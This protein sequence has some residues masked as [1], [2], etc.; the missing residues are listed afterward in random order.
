[1]THTRKLSR[2]AS[3][4][5]GKA[6]G[7][8]SLLR[9]KLAQA[10]TAETLELTAPEVVANPFPCYEALR[11]SGS[12]HFLPRHDFWLVLGYDDVNAAL[13]QPQLFSNRVRDYRQVDG[14]LLG[15][16]PPEHATAR[17]AVSHFFS[18]Q[19]LTAQAP[20]A[21]RTAERLLRPL[22]DGAEFEV[23]R[24]FAS[25]LV[26]EV[27]AHL[28]GLDKETLAAM[29][30][31]P[32]SAG[33]LESLFASFDSIIEAAAERTPLCDQLVREGG[34]VIP[35]AHARSLIR[36]LWVAGT[37]TTRRS[38][39]SS[40]LLLLRHPGVRERVASEPSLLPAF[41]EESIRL[42]PPEHMLSRAAAVETELSGV[43]IPAGATVKLCVAAANRDPS[44]FDRPESLLLGR[45]P[46][47]QLSFGGGTHRCVGAALARM[48]AATALR[49]L[50]R[51]APDFRSARPLDTLR[52]VGFANDTERLEIKC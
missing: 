32:G 39:S 25:P 30:A 42:H 36:L 12:V 11:G 14:V 6:R 17:R 24:D 28:I 31:A 2:G 45:A 5:A 10:P 44:R 20:F 26:E 27:I 1:M 16:D 13:M 18:A 29:R 34:G 46:N 19:A 49:V 40:V 51:L 43:K 8:A 15:A 38:V 22:L 52:F 7:V 47:R 35:R 23:L 33:D 41:V 3:A 48:E 21:E 50:L 9:R 37:T 4:L